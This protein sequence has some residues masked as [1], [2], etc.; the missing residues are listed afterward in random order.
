MNGRVI[1]PYKGLRMFEDSALDVP[2]FFGRER[3]RGLVEANLMA[4]RLTVL[5]GES[6]VGKSSLLRAGVA[7]HLR[8]VGRANLAERGEPELAVVVFDAWRDDPVAAL[9]RACGEEVTRALGGSLPLPQARLPLADALRGWQEI[10]GGDLYVILDQTEEYFLYHRND[11]GAGTFAAEFPAVVTS[12]SLRVNFLLAI[13]EDA[14][15]KLDASKTREA[16]V[17]SR[18]RSCNSSCAASWTQNATQN[19]TCCA[20][21]P[22][23]GSAAR[24]KSSA[25]T[26]SAR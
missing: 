26:S 6:G 2:F 23:S 16:G 25:I 12:P 19:R 1:S 22:S 11:A 8:S 5:Y 18:R 13:R 7:H 4:S 20:S 17:A 15:A 3:E 9:S 24:K 14:L 10:L 21:R